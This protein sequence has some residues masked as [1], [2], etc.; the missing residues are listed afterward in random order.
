MNDQ[1]KLL[2][3]EIYRSQLECEKNNLQETYLSNIILT[4][5]SVAILKVLYTFS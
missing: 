3:L 2:A 4:N 5:I 1:W